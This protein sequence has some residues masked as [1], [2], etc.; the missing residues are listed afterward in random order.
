MSYIIAQVLAL[1]AILFWTLSI[2]NKKKKD[3]LAFQIF[4]SLFYAIH[5]LLLG[6]YSA[7]IIDLITVARL[8]TFYIDEKKHGEIRK[9]LLYIFIVVVLISG[10][11]TYDGPISLL[12]VLIGLLYTVSTWVKNMKCLRIVYI[13]CAVLW[14]IYNFEFRAVVAAGGNLL[15]IASGI[16]SMIR[17]DR[18]KKNNKNKKRS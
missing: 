8:Y 9:S 2:Q 17:F 11:F 5:F 18:R 13:I 12:P 3:V 7:F 14:L 6:G 4:A 10:I 1:F 16:V 15:E